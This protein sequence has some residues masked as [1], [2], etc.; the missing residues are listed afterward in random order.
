M[1]KSKLK[2]PKTVILYNE[3]R[4]EMSQKWV[5][6]EARD[7]CIVAYITLDLVLQIDK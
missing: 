4:T 3:C 7:L 1:I 2:A 5:Q 6:L